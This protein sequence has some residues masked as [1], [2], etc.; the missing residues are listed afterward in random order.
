MNVDRFK[1]AKIEDR[2]QYIWQTESFVLVCWT[3]S[4]GFSSIE[5]MQNLLFFRKFH[6]LVT[7]K[8]KCQANDKSQNSN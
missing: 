3:Y 6:F 7:Q 8:T 4:F 5:K 1:I 2:M